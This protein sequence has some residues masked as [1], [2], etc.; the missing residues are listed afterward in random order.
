[1]LPYWFDKRNAGPT[2]FE[3]AP[4]LGQLVTR[5]GYIYTPPPRHCTVHARADD[6]KNC[7]CGPRAGSGAVELCVTPFHH[8]A[9][10][11]A[12]CAAALRLCA[13]Q[14]QQ[15]QC[16]APAAAAATH[17]RLLG[18]AT[19]LARRCCYCCRPPALRPQ[20]PQRPLTQAAGATH[21]AARSAAAARACRWWAR[22][23]ACASC[24][25]GWSGSWHPGSREGCATAACLSAGPWW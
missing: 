15:P 16:P 13:Q 7:L 22:S 21:D 14:H 20:Q 8:A 4:A 1:M 23:T 5:Q 25:R 3:R 18:R 19:V 24:A 12:V 11:A 17:A 2:V 10:E 6:L 9:V